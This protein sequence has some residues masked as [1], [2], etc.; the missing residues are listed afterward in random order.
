MFYVRKYLS[1]KRYIRPYH[2]SSFTLFVREIRQLHYK[3]MKFFVL[4]ALIGCALGIPT[5][6]KEDISV[7]ENNRFIDPA[8]FLAGFAFTHFIVNTGLWKDIA[9]CPV[10]K[11]Q[12]VRLR[13]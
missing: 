9:M 11:Y 1:T 5:E 2:P 4:I 6:V 3:M 10:N 13:T 7:V 8:S 12:N